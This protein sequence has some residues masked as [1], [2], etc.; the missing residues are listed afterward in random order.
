CRVVGVGRG[1]ARPK[2]NPPPRRETGEAGGRDDTI[3][4]YSELRRLR[5]RS[6]A[7]EPSVKRAVEGSGVGVR[8]RA[9]VWPLIVPDAVIWPK[10]LIG[11]PNPFSERFVTPVP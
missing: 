3:L 2:E 6:S 4:G 5:S 8:R 9:C 11:L 7:P 1:C 10:S